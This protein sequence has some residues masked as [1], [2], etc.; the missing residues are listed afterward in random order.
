MSAKGHQGLSHTEVNEKE[1]ST[2]GGPPKA[3]PRRR[4]QQRENLIG[5]MAIEAAPPSRTVTLAPG[6]NPREVALVNKAAELGNIGKLPVRI[7]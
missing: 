3:V 6:K 7:L 2:C 5:L 4:S 1:K